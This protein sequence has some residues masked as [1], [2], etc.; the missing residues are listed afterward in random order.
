MNSV[1]SIVLPLLKN[2]ANL[3]A[4]A[5]IS[6]RPYPLPDHPLA[7]VRK[8]LSSGIST[9]TLVQATVLNALD[10]IDTSPPE[11]LRSPKLE[12]LN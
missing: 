5:E 3:P 1:F 10:I 7:L 9:T 4:D 2:K 8:A 12:L 6:Y 11:A